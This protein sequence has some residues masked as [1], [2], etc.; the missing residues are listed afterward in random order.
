MKTLIVEDDF[1]SRILLQQILSPFGEC[2]IA[3]NGR[4]AIEAFR[5]A[6]ESR[7]SYD[8]VCLD[9]MMPEM[10]GQSVL[11][12]I[13]EMERA[14]AVRPGH[15]VKVI[16]TTAL[17]DPRNVFDAFKSLCDAYLVKPIKKAELIRRIRSFGLIS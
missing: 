11:K 5:S 7:S 15:G 10:D 4:E 1:T 8:L 17:D 16:M 6:G 13:R 12:E 3:V 14:R 9:V 2:H